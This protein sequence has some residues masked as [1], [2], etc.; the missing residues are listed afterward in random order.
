MEDLNKLAQELKVVNL[1]AELRII[2]PDVEPEMINAIFIQCKKGDP[3]WVLD[4]ISE[5]DYIE[6][7]SVFWIKDFHGP[8]KAKGLTSKD[9]DITRLTK[10]AL[11]IQ[12]L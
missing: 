10:L 1:M 2:F 9:F 11:N 3:D 4:M 12:A 7:K 8:L 5:L 6:P